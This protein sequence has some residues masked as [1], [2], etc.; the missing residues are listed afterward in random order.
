MSRPAN[1][2]QKIK[3]R[4]VNITSHGTFTAVHA[5]QNWK[6]FITKPDWNPNK[7]LTRDSFELTPFCVHDGKEIVPPN[8]I[9]HSCTIPERSGY[10]VI[11]ANW[12]V[13]NTR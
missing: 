6:Y 5:T 11:Y 12:E 8:D 1:A 7:V 3:F 13:S 2:G 4:R 10:H 9:T